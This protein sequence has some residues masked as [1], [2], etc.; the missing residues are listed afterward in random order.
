MVTS[1]ELISS[2]Y[3]FPLLIDMPLYLKLFL[4][5]SSKTAAIP[6]VATSF[7]VISWLR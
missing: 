4:A 3:F 5:L 2:R 1:K 6:V 7:T